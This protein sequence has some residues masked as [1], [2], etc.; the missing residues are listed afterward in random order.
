MIYNC[1]SCGKSF[2]RTGSRRPKYC[3]LKCKSVASNARD[4]ACEVCGKIF[5]TYG[6]RPGRF[7]SRTC[8]GVASRLPV[9]LCAV[10]GK[11]FKPRMG[12]AD[13]PC[14]SRECG[15]VYR[16]TGFTVACKQCGKPAYV[17]QSQA[18]VRAFCS[19]E[20][21]NRWQGRNKVDFTCKM[22]SKPFRW[23]PS[24]VNS[25]Q[26][27]VT[28][29]SLAC[30][31]A[32]PDR[33]EMLMELNR[34]QQTLK[35][36]G[37]ERSGYALLDGIGVDYL[38]QHIIGDK[39]CVDAFIPSAGLVVQF[40]GDYWHGN[41]ARFPEP[42]RRQRHRINLDRS[43]DAYMKACGYEV[44]RIWASDLKS[45]REGVRS[46]LL[47]ALA[48]REHAP[49][50]PGSDPAAIEPSHSRLVQNSFRF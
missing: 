39:F 44:F 42:D 16:R 5:R 24:R 43:Q 13:Q 18:E 31:D 41:P 34:R 47:Q 49:A 14:C 36:N 11:D 17:P 45:D 6:T 15:Y 19:R 46:R 1:E 26:Y 12:C 38:P 37:V 33:R 48:E 2:A 22:C 7:C 29:C 10:C 20:C 8:K 32:D 28:Y 23:S 3:S 27:N 30:R 35:I 25:G 50:V 40:D 4:V 9:K 21:H